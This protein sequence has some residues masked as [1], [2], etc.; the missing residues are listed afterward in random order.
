MHCAHL[1][2][3]EIEVQRYFSK[4]LKVTQQAVVRTRNETEV[5]LT[6]Q[7]HALIPSFPPERTVVGIILLVRW[8]VATS[9]APL[10]AL[11]HY[12]PTVTRLNH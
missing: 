9:T 2:D 1:T 8:A 10:K 5:Y 7:N 4:L 12:S 3:G 6:P 11:F